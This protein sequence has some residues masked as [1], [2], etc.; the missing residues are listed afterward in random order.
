MTVVATVA[1]KAARRPYSIRSSPL[2]SRTNF[3]I[4]L[5]MAHHL[6]LG[7]ETSVTGCDTTSGI[8]EDILGS[9]EGPHQRRLDSHR[10]GHDGG[11]RDGRRERREQSVLDQVFATFIGDETAH[12]GH[13]GAALSPWL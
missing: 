9:A 4:S 8:F 11:G 1:T 2:S 3:N 10:V 7:F 12:G 6:L 13:R 5:L